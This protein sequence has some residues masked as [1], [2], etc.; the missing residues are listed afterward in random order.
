MSC[1]W[2]ESHRMLHLVF[3]DNEQ[4]CSHSSG[5]TYFAKRL[6][7]WTCFTQNLEYT[8]ILCSEY[9]GKFSTHKT[10]YPIGSLKNNSR[11]RKF[12]PSCRKS[13]ISNQHRP[14][15]KHVQARQ[16]P[17]TFMHTLK[18]ENWNPLDFRSIHTLD[19]GSSE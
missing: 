2:S 18:C 15:K 6:L 11:D 13:R 5:A 10:L 1:S 12:K 17:L 14:L 4:W 3:I 9:I 8:I 7:P 19:F 16:S